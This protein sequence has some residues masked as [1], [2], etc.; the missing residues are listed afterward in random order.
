MTSD[1]VVVDEIEVLERGDDVLLLH[2]GQ[3]ADLTEEP[4]NNN[5]RNSVNIEPYIMRAFD[6]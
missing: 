6:E 3:L 2:T 5:L 4:P 1:L